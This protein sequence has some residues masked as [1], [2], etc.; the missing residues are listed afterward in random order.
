[1]VSVGFLPYA[2]VAGV[3]TLLATGLVLTSILA[4]YISLFKGYRPA[5]YFATAWTVLLIGVML[6][7]LM[8]I[9]LMPRNF[10]TT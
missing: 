4:A 1:M 9:G 5:R 6:Y 7:A 2:L 10:L 8:L 3:V